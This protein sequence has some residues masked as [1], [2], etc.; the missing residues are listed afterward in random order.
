MLCLKTGPAT[1]RPGTQ[2]IAQAKFPHPLDYAVR[3]QEFQFSVDTTFIFECGQ[4]YIRFYS[5]GAQVNVSSAPL[6][7]TASQYFEG[8]YVTDPTDDLIYYCVADV[9]GGTTEP[10]LDVANWVQ[11]TI[12]EVPTPYDA[13]VD[14]D[15]LAATEVF[16]LQFCAINDVVYIVHPAHPRYKLTRVTDEHWTMEP[17]VDT[18]PALLDQNATDVSIAA[19]ST[20]GQTTLTASA[21]PWSTAFYYQIGAAVTEVGVI[22]AC[23]VAHV[24]GVFADD[25][26]AG[27][28]KPQTIFQIGH[29]G[30]FWELSNLRDSAYIEYRG[31]AAGGFAAGTSAT[32]IAFGAWEVHTYGVWSA[33]I[34]VQSS[35]D[36]GVTWQTVRALTGRLDRNADIKGTA[37]RAQLYRIVVSNVAA[38]GT[39]G[40]TDPRVVFECVDAFLFGIVQITE[41]GVD[42]ASGMV[43]GT[44]YQINVLG[45]TNWGDLGAPPDFMVG[46]IFQYNGVAVTGTGGMVTTPYRAIAEVKT[47]LP[48]ANAWISGQGYSAGDHANYNGINYVALNAVASATPPPSD[49]TNW[50]AGG[51]PTIYWSEGAWSDVRGYPRAIAAFGQKIWCGFTD[52][53]PQRMW[54]TQTDDIENWDLG[55][56]TL[57]TDGLAFDLDAVGDGAILWIQSQDALFVG[58]VSAE[59]VVSSSDQSTGITPTSIAAHR[60]SRWGSNKNIPARVVGDALV[61]ITR[62]AYSIRQM[63][64]SIA[65]EKFMSQDLTALS[66]NIL[67]LGGLQMAYQHQGQKNGF[68]WVTTKN[69]ELVGM[70]YE[71]NQEVFGWHRHFTGPIDDPDRFES[72]AVIPGK[73]NNDDEVWVV[74]R[75]KIGSSDTLQR[76]VERINPTNWYAD[77][78]VPRGTSGYPANKNLAYYVDCGRSFT[79]PA[80]NV[81]AG[82]DHLI[83]KSV[84]VCI[85]AQDYGL[86]VVANDGT[87]TVP[88]YVWDGLTFP[89]TYAHIGLPFTSTV[90]PMNLDSDHQIGSTVGLK[91]KLTYLYISFLNTLGGKVSAGNANTIREL[92][93]R[94][95]NQLLTPPPLYSGTYEIRDFPGALGLEVPLLLLNDGPLP[96]T[97]LGIAISYDV[98]G[99]P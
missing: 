2:F 50:E 34:F 77:E 43:M 64:F 12:L 83:G 39:P 88:D 95:G 19:S 74:V 97:C 14:A 45:T 21:P 71:F 59:W 5:N 98:A 57:A 7:V 1:R 30:S 20:T 23:V 36:G 61:F 73:G 91:K 4:H 56:Q 24:S 86:F 10:H 87:V 82:F 35:S 41:F 75:R 31:T 85:N 11:R 51:Y 62:Q 65:T 67:N 33:D 48:S 52:F 38:P 76:Y 16:Q 26:A 99:T 8:N 84:S 55:D 13:V 60:Q 17:V 53:E 79:N 6:W 66:D 9:S 58:L 94:P 49:P 3:L 29:I 92:N 89:P 72:V 27:Y 78:L 40:A 96:T 68:L 44:T 32:I 54:G 70:T 46:T 90:Q 15:G 42:V 81:F 25:L 63:L 93:F 47:Q 18:V 22:Y 69:G 28:W 37:V 80:T